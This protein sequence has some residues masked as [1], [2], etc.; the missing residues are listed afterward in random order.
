MLTPPCVLNGDACW[1]RIA[2]IPHR[3]I[4]YGGPAAVSTFVENE[5]A[6]TSDFR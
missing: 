6:A 3:F 2:S 1:H 5:L 4:T